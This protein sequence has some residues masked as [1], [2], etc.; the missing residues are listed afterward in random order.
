[1]GLDGLDISTYTFIYSFN[2]SIEA[3]FNQAHILFHIAVVFLFN[4][5]ALNI[6]ALSNPILC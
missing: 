1:M 5:T 3:L 4:Q 6:S 2:V